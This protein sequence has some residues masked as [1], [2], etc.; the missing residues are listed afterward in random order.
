[1][2]KVSQLPKR[3]T[4]KRSA[5]NFDSTQA[6]TEAIKILLS[7]LGAGDREKVIDELIAFVRPIPIERA[8]DV[9]GAIVRF[10]RPRQE[11][12]VEDLKTAVK[13]AGFEAKPKEVYNAVGYLTRKGHMRRVGYGRYVVDG[14]EI[15]TADDIGGESSR[16]EDGYRL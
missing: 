9:L 4:D 13:E 15:V 3:S 14:V 16:H 1:M 6:V 11:L 10:L 8:G 2:A 12:S 7:H 5:E